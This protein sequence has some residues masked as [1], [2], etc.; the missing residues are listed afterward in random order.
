MNDYQADVICCTHTGIKWH[1][2]LTQNKHFINV[3]VIGRPENDGHTHVWFAVLDHD[4][5]QLHCQFHSLEY[6]YKKLAA[7]IL[8]EGLP[9]EFATTIQTG[10]WTTCLEIMPSKERARGKF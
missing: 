3:G 4:G 6:D 2:A 10:W 9:K 8:E 5:K 1:R 7:E